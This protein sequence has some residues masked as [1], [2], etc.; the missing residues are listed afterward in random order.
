MKPTVFLL[1]LAKKL[2]FMILADA[3]FW[4]NLEQIAT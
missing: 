1:K 2:P 3:E 4:L